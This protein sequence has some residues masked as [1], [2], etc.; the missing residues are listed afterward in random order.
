MSVEAPF[1][2]RAIPELPSSFNVKE[3]VVAGDRGACGGVLRAIEATQ[4]ILGHVARIKDQTGI[5]IPVSA[6]HEIVHH[7]PISRE[8]ESKGLTIEPDWRKVPPGSI[9]LRSAHGT[10]PSIIEALIVNGVI[11]GNLECQLVT[12]DRRSAEATLKSGKDL[13]YF[14]VP[15]H[16]EPQAV[17][18]DLDPERAHFFDVRK[19]PREIDLPVRP[20]DVLSQT[21]ISRRKVEETVRVWGETHPETEVP[22]FEDGPCV[23]TDNRQDALY[24]IYSDPDKPIDLAIT[25]AS[26]SSHNGE[27]L[28]LIAEEALKARERMSI[29]VDSITSLDTSLFTQDVQRIALTSAASVLDRFMVPFLQL[30]QK[31]GASIRVNP[32]KERYG[33]FAVPKDLR[34][35]QNHLVQAYGIN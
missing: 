23:I 10:P 30:F 33:S 9:H 26:D 1:N 20:F 34:V 28:R 17:I 18:G 8:L 12:A 35:I 21:T 31:G 27:E 29:A 11:V 13:A 4:I 2:H 3:V 24:E 32:G 19:K 22:I 14:G 7:E 15:G 6:N 5:V 25:I 16:P